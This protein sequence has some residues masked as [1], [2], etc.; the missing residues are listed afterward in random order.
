LCN[1]NICD[2]RRKIR[3]VKALMKCAKTPGAEI[4]DVDVPAIGPR[5]VLLKVKATAICGS[6]IHIYDWGPFAQT[7]IRPPMIFGHEGCGEVVE[8]GHQVTNISIGD[9]VAVET[10]IPDNKCYQCQIGAQHICE[11]MAIIGV[12]TNGVFAE[13]ARIPAVCCWK[14]SSNTNPDLGAIMEPIGVAVNGALKEEINNKSVAVFGCGPIGLFCLGALNFW[15]ATKIFAIEPRPNR[16]NMVYQFAPSA[17]PI[18]PQEKDAVMMIREAT[19][20]R[21]VDVAIDISGSTE[22]IKMAFKVL[23]QG[24]RITLIG[25]P[26]EPVAISLDEDIIYKEARVFGSTGRIMWKTWWDVQKLIKYGKFDPMPV[27]THRFPL[28]EFEKALRLAKGKEAG[29]IML[30]P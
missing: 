27:I 5:D 30:Y 8:V 15:G 11:N 26:S 10:H 28:A 4:V 7:R 3:E 12:H 20:G 16:L 2:R 17:I 25:I 21:G 29:K 18:N 19:E 14:L 13:Y 9:L 6:D 23:A 22:A 24:G 1:K